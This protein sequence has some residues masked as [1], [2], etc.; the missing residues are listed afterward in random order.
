MGAMEDPIVQEWIANKY[1]YIKYRN[2]KDIRGLVEKEGYDW[3][4]TK[5]TFNSTGSAEDNNLLKAAWLK[6]WRPYPAHIK[7][8]TEK[9]LLN[10]FKW[11]MSNPKYQTKSFKS[12]FGDVEVERQVAPKDP[13]DRKENVVYYHNQKAVDAFNSMDDN[14][15]DKEASDALNALNSFIDK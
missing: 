5:Q 2:R 4:S 14:I 3:N 1:N 8:P 12:R 13:K 11:L 9:D 7:E 6:G 15:T 10:A